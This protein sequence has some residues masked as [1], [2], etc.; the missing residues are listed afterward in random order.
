[1]HQVSKDKEQISQEYPKS[2]VAIGWKCPSFAI[3]RFCARMG[4]GADG[5]GELADRGVYYASFTI[6]D[7]INYLIGGRGAEHFL[8]SAA[9]ITWQKAMSKRARCSF[10]RF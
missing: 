8:Y 3:D 9:P 2:F 6:P 1:M 5:Q 4:F 10:D 7:S